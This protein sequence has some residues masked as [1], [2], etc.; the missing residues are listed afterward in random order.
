MGRVQA[1]DQE[2]AGQV[3]REEARALD[4]AD[5]LAS[6]KQR[7]ALPQGV[8]YLDGNSLGALPKA[9][10]D[11][12]ADATNRQWGERLI[13]SWNEGWMESP[14]RI[15]AKIAALIGAAAREVIVADST[16][17]NLFKL[18]VAALR[19]DPARRVIVSEQGN[20]P[21][22]L[23][24]AEGAAGCVPGAV[25]KAVPRGEIAAAL[26]RDTAVL[27][28]THVHYKTGARFDM[29]AMTAAAHKAGAVVL[30]DLS[31]STGAIP[32]DLTAAGADLA[33]GCT[34]KYLNGSPGAPAFLYVAARWQER[35]ASPL[36]GWMGHAAPFAFADAYSPA[37]GMTR[38]LAGTPPILAMAALEGG[39]DLW[40]N[41]DRD[42][43]WKKSEALF[44]ILAQAGD[45]IGLE[46]V[47]PRKAAERGSHISFRHPDAYAII[48][49][50]IARGVIGDFREPDIL[51]F[52]LTPLYLSHEDAWNAGDI[53]RDV[54]LTKAWRDP[55]FSERKPIT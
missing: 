18:L 40:H 51:R 41:V 22:D 32:V 8:I 33:V 20:F 28:L 21:T 49:A 4:A 19:I 47:T 37:L 14:Q 24:V 11:V 26:G 9:T 31:H 53:L 6:M 46:C 54:M 30:W 29:T 15:G 23:H 55:Q 16:S 48:Q 36:S 12:L 43:V 50:L 52:G 34:Y 13:R 5:P 39:I 2:S 35:L 45:L 44:G 42:V 27:V 10:V 25:L 3:T 38:W 17:A 1:A 7:F